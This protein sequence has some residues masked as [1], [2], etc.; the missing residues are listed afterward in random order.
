MLQ[1][2]KNM[3]P[4]AE[5]SIITIHYGRQEHLNNL[6][7]GIE[8]N[9]IHPK[10][11]IIINMDPK[12]K[13]DYN[14]PLTINLNN[15]LSDRANLLPI[16]NARNLGAELAET[17]HLLF[18]D[19]DCIPEDSYIK[20]LNNQLEVYKGLIMATPR[21]LKKPVTRVETID[22]IDK[23]TLHPRRPAYS[24]VTLID[25]Y[26]LFWSLCFA[27]TKQDFKALQGFDEEYKGYGAEDTDFAF[28]AKAA[29]MKFCLSPAIAFHQQH[30]F[31]RPP[32][33]KI[34]GI[35]NNANYFN[36]KWNIWPMEKALKTFDKAGFITF[37]TSTNTYSINH[38]PDEHS[39]EKYR[40]IN[41]P[42]A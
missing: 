1:K 18:L 34:E 31:V 15:I 4:I 9:S 10:E 38:L 32:L 3:K 20:N 36:K 35:V 40:V 14:G 12:L 16:A 30:S 7:L 27:M 42:F 19:V 25:H 33:D 11:L 24:K 5:C 29:G 41:E 2:K 21:Y 39:I 28:K 13:L 8:R 22:L 17:N 23:S 26:E 37:D 6:I